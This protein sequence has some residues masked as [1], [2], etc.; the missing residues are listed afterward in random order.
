[1]LLLPVLRI[2]FQLNPH[3]DERFPEDSTR[4]VKLH[5]R[6]PALHG[7][8]RSGSIAARKRLPAP[9]CALLLTA[10]NSVIPFCQ[11]LCNGQIAQLQ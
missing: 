5:R 8:K 7:S 11:A 6:S 10:F 9:E 2:E 3:L 1:M 4:Q